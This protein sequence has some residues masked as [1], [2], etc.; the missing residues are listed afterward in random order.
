MFGY[1]LDR[2]SEDLDFDSQYKITTG[3]MISVLKTLNYQEIKI[4]KDT[5][6]TKRI[7]VMLDDVSIK[8]E[9]SLRNM[10]KQSGQKKNMIGNIGIYSLD[11]LANMK[12]DAF[13]NRTRARDLYDLG[14]IA[15]RKKDELSVQTQHRF[16]EKFGEID[17]VDL[18]LSSET[19]FREDNILTETD[20]FE[21][22]TRLRKGI[23]DIVQRQ[24]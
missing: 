13:E 17:F 9:V 12:L 2:F 4:K 3:S 11:A 5:D 21:S 18:L 10:H 6:T 19:T 8:I 23:D 22:I 1:G 24:I 16:L 14:Y 7:L 15:C 20:L